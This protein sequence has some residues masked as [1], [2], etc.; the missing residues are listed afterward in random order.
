MCNILLTP[1]QETIISQF[2]AND[3]EMGCYKTFN[4]LN[5]YQQNHVK[6]RILLRKKLHRALGISLPWRKFIELSEEEKKKR[7]QAIRHFDYDRLSNQEMR[8]ALMLNKNE[9]DVWRND[10][11]QV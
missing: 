6:E 8:E 11:W 9:L 1:E 2:T 4:L 5:E 7:Y 3:P 10:R